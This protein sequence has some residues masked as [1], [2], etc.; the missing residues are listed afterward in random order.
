MLSHS[1]SVFLLYTLQ[2]NHLEENGNLHSNHLTKQ[3][4]VL[5]TKAQAPWTGESLSSEWCPLYINDKMQL[6]KFVIRRLVH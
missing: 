3:V 5:R 4:A 6:S 1:S 2:S